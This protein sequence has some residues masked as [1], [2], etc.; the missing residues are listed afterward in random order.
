M[1]VTKS[2]PEIEIKLRVTDASALRIR[3][4]KLRA[5]EIIPRTYECN[6][7]FDTPQ[8]TLTRRGQLIRIRTERLASKRSH[9]RPN[10]T[11]TAILTYKGPAPKSRHTHGSAKSSHRRFKIREEI[12][13]TLS[14]GDRTAG[15]L[16]AIGLRP[17][18]R[19]EKFRTTYLLPGVRKL[20]VEFDETPA[21][22]FLELEGNPASIDQ[23]ARLLGYRQSDYMT[24]T[25]GELHIADCRRRGVKPGDMLFPSTKQK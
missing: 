7:L 8:K 20:K 18:F 12:E 3:L 17:V 24:Q 19:Y 16:R 4:K 11:P 22:Q 9:S 23:A 6:T 1:P 14:G 10:Q 21:G 25:Y 15:I 13:V 2:R 5:R